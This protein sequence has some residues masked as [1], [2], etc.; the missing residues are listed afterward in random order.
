MPIK[1]IVRG[2]AVPFSKLEKAKELRLNQT[3]A[4]QVLWQALRAN[5]FQGL[6][7]R[8]QQVISGFIVD[9]YCHA[10]ELV[11]EVDGPI[12]AAQKEYDAEREQVLMDKG[13][14]VL[15]VSND[16]VLQRLPQVLKKIE[17]HSSPSLL[18]KEPGDR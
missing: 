14:C 4:E 2:Q 10:G 16:D 7:F 15:R 8:R 3:E 12:H 17:E 1:N 11:I 9:F 18:G 5:R 13:L 6:H